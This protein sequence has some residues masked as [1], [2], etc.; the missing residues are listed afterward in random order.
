LAVSQRGSYYGVMTKGLVAA[1]L[2]GSLMA[3]TMPAPERL[4]RWKKGGMPFAGAGLA[5]EGSQ[6]GE[7]LVEA[8]RLLDRVYWEQSD[9][10]GL[11]LLRSTRDADLKRLLTTMGSRWD[12]IDENRPFTGSEAM[13]PGRE[14]YPKGITRAEI[15]EYVRKHPAEKAAIYD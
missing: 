5:G 8:C 6:M 1:A 14:L 2:A 4:A 10:A 7:K 13:P 15:E 9:R 11:A 3:A 12:L